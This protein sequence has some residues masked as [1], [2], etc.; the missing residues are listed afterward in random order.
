MNKMH[1]IREIEGRTLFDRAFR[2]ELEIL[3]DQL[4]QFIKSS[5]YSAAGRAA[6]GIVMRIRCLCINELNGQI[7]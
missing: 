5:S 3:S 2:P 4:E 1:V 7:V 6:N